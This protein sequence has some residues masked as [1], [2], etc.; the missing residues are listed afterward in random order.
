MGIERMLSGM[1]IGEVVRQVLLKLHNDLI[2]LKT[3]PKQWE[4]MYGL[5]TELVCSIL[6]KDQEISE[7]LQSQGLTSPTALECRLIYRICQMVVI[8]A[9][10]LVAALLACTVDRVE[11]SKVGIAV[12]G[13]VYKNMELFRDVL[14]EKTKSLIK[15]GTDCYFVPCEDGSGLGAA[16]VAS[17]VDRKLRTQ[18]N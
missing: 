2:I 5:T 3:W 4:K 12:D 16:I 9:A 15:P 10:E 11:D 8:R 13:S 6:E 17:M 14:K 18:K 7:L 1:F